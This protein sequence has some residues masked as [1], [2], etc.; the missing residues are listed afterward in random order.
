MD[1]VAP[2]L[3]IPVVGNEG[4]AALA[5]LMDPDLAFYAPL[6]TSLE[7]E[8]GIGPAT[9]TRASGQN[10]VDHEGL[11]IALD[12]NEA[13]FTGARRVKN[14]YIAG[15]DDIYNW[16]DH[17]GGI[18]TVVATQNYGMAPDGTMTATRLQLS[19]SGATSSS[20]LAGKLINHGLAS[21]DSKIASWWIRS[22]S[23]NVVVRLNN[24]QQR[25]DVTVTEQW[26]RF[27]PPSDLSV[28][29][30]SEIWLRY[31]YPTS[32][33]VDLLVWGCMVEKTTGQAKQ[34]ASEFAP[35]ST[36]KWFN[37]TN[38]NTVS[39]NIVTEGSGTLL[40]GIKGYYSEEGADNRQ[41]QKVANLTT[42]NLCGVLSVTWNDASTT[43]GWLI[44]DYTDAN[45]YWGIFHLGTTL[46]LRKRIAGVNYDA[47]IALTRVGGVTDKIA[48]RLSSTTGIAIWLNGTKGT[49]NANTSAVTNTSFEIGSDG[50]GANQ[51][52]ASIKLSRLYHA[53]K[54]DSFMSSL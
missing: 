43:L 52:G 8:I 29:P 28:D 53:D 12:T 14:E 2:S 42:N 38:G 3:R 22:L 25:P 41:V 31:G 15:Y 9:F 44:G 20:D 51:I 16:Q 32:E 35:A 13:G 10:V 7:P 30:V 46:T 48:F 45:N 23:G 27:Q 33:T 47:T 24:G 18:G 37:T 36:S 1:I 54:S 49:G 19:I 39:S 40:T 21:P 26:Q 5:G 11:S 50:N 34:V 17:I 4:E 6:E